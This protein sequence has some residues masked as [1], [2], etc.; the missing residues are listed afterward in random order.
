MT[1]NLTKRKKEKQ[2]EDTMS[3]PLERESNMVLNT[4]GEQPQEKDNDD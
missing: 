2:L 3:K 1:T 4:H